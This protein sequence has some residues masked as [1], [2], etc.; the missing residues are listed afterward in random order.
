MIRKQKSLVI[1]CVCNFLIW[2][3][4]QKFLWKSIPLNWGNWN[5][6]IWNCIIVINRMLVMP[7]D[8]LQ[9]NLG[10]SII[11]FHHILLWLAESHFGLILWKNIQ[12]YFII[13]YIQGFVVQI[14]LINWKYYK[15][16]VE[17]YFFLYIIVLFLWNLPKQ[18][19]RNR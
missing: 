11:V 4:I 6:P 8:L 2:T 16:N 10:L 7:C 18:M 13:Q 5:H 1:L 9:M 15:K 17:K 19:W 14:T 12:T 3:E